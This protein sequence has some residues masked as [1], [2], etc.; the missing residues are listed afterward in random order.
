VVGAHGSAVTLA[1]V[2]LN[3]PLDMTCSASPFPGCDSLIV[4]AQLRELA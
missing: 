4:Q 2:K 3:A 1:V